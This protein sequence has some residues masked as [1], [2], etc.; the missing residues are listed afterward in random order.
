[1]SN[2][3]LPHLPHHHATAMRGR[4]PHEQH[5]T[6]TPLELLFDLTFVIAFGV[7]GS[8]FAHMLA[9]GHYWTGI[10]SFCFAMFAICLAWINFSWFA[11]AFDTDDWI[12][13]LT[14]MVQMVGVIVLA[15]GLPEMFTS[16]DQGGHVDNS[17]MVLGY[18]IMRAAMISQWLRAA[19]QYPGGRAACLFYATWITIAQIG[20]TALIFLDMPLLPTAACI[21]F[22]GGFELL[23]PIVAEN[24][25]NGTPWHAH[26]MA[27]RYGLLAIIAL[28]EGLIGTVAS[29]SAILELQGWTL[30]TILMGV[31]GTGL[32]F[33]MWWLYFMLPSAK[34]L[35]HR[36]DRSFV[37][38]YGHILIFGAIAATGAGLHVAA[39][40]IEHEAHIGAV[41]T[42]LTVVLPVALYI[43]MIFGLY[44][45]LLGEKDPFHLW[46][47]AGTTVVLVLPVGAAALGINVTICLTILMFAPVVPVVG[48]EAIGHR[49][50][51]AVLE[52]IVASRHRARADGESIH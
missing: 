36:R 2:E 3:T 4:D 24:R 17:V 35:H 21:V 38:G 39:Y 29:I 1:M 37:W 32:T 40:F 34:V 51:N 19:R 41:A 8:Q 9:E 46:L 6:A 44:S 50:G 45:Y 22:L 28:G 31:A 11:S 13:R 26:H 49:H 27:E 5:R 20:W 10:A 7:A 48:Y 18:V 12:Y 16:L 43:A 42:V 33:G 52:R 30:E 47:L 15:V 23:G 14:T 25:G